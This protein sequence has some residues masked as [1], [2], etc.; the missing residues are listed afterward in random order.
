M[1]T[2]YT[3]VTVP[4]IYVVAIIHWQ[5]CK[6]LIKDQTNPHTAS[7]CLLLQKWVL[8]SS[9]GMRDHSLHF[10]IHR[11]IAYPPFRFCKAAYCKE[12]GR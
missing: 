9:T 12:T 10:S 5:C 2:I 6:V 4:L 1:N 3:E 11:S 7:P 8:E